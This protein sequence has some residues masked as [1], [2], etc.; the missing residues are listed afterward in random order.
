MASDID[1]LKRFIYYDIDIIFQFTEE[2][3]QDLI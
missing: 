1:A 2:N 3:W